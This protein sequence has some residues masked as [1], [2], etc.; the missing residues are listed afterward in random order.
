MKINFLNQY[1]KNRASDNNASDLLNMYLEEDKDQ[2]KYNVI[3][4]PTPGKTVFNSDAGSVVRGGIE[5][6]GVAYFVVDDTFYSYTSNGTRTSRGTLNTSSGRIQLAS[7]SNQIEIVDGTD[8]YNY[9][10]GTT[11]FT[12]VSDADRPS[13]PIGVTAQ[14]EFFLIF[15]S[16]SSIVYGSDVADGTSF[17]ALSFS[18]KTGPGDYVNGLMSSNEILHVFGT[19]TSDNWYNS[20]AATFSFEPIGLGGFFH[21]GCIAPNSVA[22]GANTVF[23]LGQNEQGGYCVNM[24]D[25]YDVK[26]ISNRAV[27]YQLSL[28]T[29][30]TDAQGFCYKQSGHEFY[31]LTF[32]TEAKTFMYDATTGLWS[33]LQSYVSAAYTRDLANCHVFCYGKNLVGAFNSGTIY[34]LDPTVYQENGTAIK[35]RIVTPPGYAAGKKVFM[36]RLQV[37]LQTNVGS[38][39]QIDL[40]VSKDSGVTY[41]AFASQNIPSTGG[42]MFWTRLGMTQNAF[43][44]RLSTTSNSKFC[45]LGAVAEIR[46][47]VH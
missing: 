45:V 35:R 11:T 14:D 18:T 24:M 12:T 47:G 37:D 23:F 28:L 43:V 1:F 27:D 10:T 7:I 41:T 21:Y 30:L 16:N 33:E 42:R 3:A 38:S 36:D 29:T 8:I 20:G 17:N 15:C 32:P 4:L 46:T 40:D 22:K 26:P 31:V 2:G 19:K 9:N 34:Y 39:L 25:Q 44:L 6:R 5:H 13:N